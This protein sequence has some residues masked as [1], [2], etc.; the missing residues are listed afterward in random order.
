M[1]RIIDRNEIERILTQDAHYR[2]E[3]KWP[4]LTSKHFDLINSHAN[5]HVIDMLNVKL[6]HI[7]DN[8]HFNMHDFTRQ[9][10][11]KYKFVSNI[12]CKFMGHLVACGGCIISTLLEPPAIEKHL[13]NS[14]LDLFFYDLSLEEANKMR[15]A[16][17]CEIIGSWK[18]WLDD[19]AKFIVKRNEFVTSVYVFL[20]DRLVVEYQLIH[21]IYPDIS[22]IIGGFDIGACM[23][24]YDGCEIYATP[25]GA[26]SLQN[27]SIIVDTKR[28]S[29]SYEHRLIKYFKRGFR[30]IFPGLTTDVNYKKI[31]GSASESEE[32]LKRQILDLIKG[33]GYKI[34]NIDNII[35]EC[36]KIQNIVDN[37]IPTQNIII[38][39]GHADNYLSL[40]RYN[41]R[42]LSE[43]SLNKMSDYYSSELNNFDHFIPANT[44]KL[45]LGNLKAVSSLVIICGSHGNIY[46]MLINDINCPDLQLNEKSINRYK[47]KIHKIKSRLENRVT[48]W[49]NNCNFYTLMNCFGHLANE[50]LDLKDI[51]EYD[52]YRDIMITVMIDN[53]KICKKKLT[54]IKWITD[55]PGRQWTSSINPII[56]NPREWYGEDYVP[57]VTGIPV[58]IESNLRLIR[59]PRTESYWSY[60]PIEIFDLILF[61]ISKSYA[62]EAWQ[63]I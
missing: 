56:A 42:L 11:E 39:K 40:T 21:R 14:D 22:S 26:W 62:D 25:L 17:I 55:N 18:S 16:V 58:D 63:Y 60:L 28:R 19:D 48:W 35:N 57:V 36:S 20:D 30:I 50:V 52:N 46:E 5:I 49:N 23:L 27:K 44:T 4:L 51:N 34:N 15:I 2:K 32:I 10:N 6:R 7:Q 13:K 37:N 61:Y 31:I 9:I 47:T 1:T 53:A 3:Q 24:A 8:I 29:T 38:L 12:L 59:L 41:N 45:R 33:C 43:K 54:G